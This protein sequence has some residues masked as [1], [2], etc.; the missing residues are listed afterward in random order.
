MRSQSSRA[1]FLADASADE[2]KLAMNRS[3]AFT[4]VS[5]AVSLGAL[6]AAA[7]PRPVAP[8]TPAAPAASPEEPTAAALEMCSSC[9]PAAVTG[10]TGTHH[11][12]VEQSCARCHGDVAA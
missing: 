5:L 4:A 9:H 12:G 11:A 2:G 8:Q 3:L 10:L 7:H 1:C 6:G